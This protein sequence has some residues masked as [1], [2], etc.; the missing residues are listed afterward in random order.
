M[1]SSAFALLHFIVAESHKQKYRST[2][3]LRSQYVYSYLATSPASKN[4][5][6]KR[7]KGDRFGQQ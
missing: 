5:E 1:F 2:V 6:P 7:G 4:D 3:P